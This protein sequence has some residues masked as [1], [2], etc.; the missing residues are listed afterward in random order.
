MAYC[1]RAIACFLNESFCFRMPTGAS[2]IHPAALEPER[3]LADCEV[4]R[5]RAGGPGGQHRNKVETAIRIR[6]RPT[7]TVAAASE[8]RRAEENR[9]RAI[10]RLRLRLAL[11]VRRP[12]PEAR[13]PSRLWRSRRVQ[14]GRLAVRADHEDF[15][16][17][18]AEALDAA[19]GH[20]ADLAAAAGALGVSTSQLI[21]LLRKAPEALAEVNR[22]RRACGA[23]VYR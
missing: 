13:T 6:H 17:L 15:P 10:F 20:G 23:H 11:E 18:L 19:E 12:W 2:S 22:Q 21:K 8:R 5:T 4:E 7:G 1:T 16:A 9:R 3:L 14:A